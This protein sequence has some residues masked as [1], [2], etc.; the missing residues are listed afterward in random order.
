MRGHARS[1]MPPLQLSAGAGADAPL[2]GLGPGRHC[3][4]VQCFA[5][6]SRTE[7]ENRLE[8]SW[9]VR[10]LVL[11][12]VGSFTSGIESR[13]GMKSV[14]FTAKLIPWGMESDA[15]RLYRSF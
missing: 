7:S 4:A 13:S 5:V 15:L 6:M 1:V 11:S 12:G 8:R 3:A 14:P 9:S 2:L 10:V